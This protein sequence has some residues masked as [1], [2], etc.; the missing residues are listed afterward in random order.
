MGEG[1]V[2]CVGPNR[3]V[4]VGTLKVRAVGVAFEEVYEA[5]AVVGHLDMFIKIKV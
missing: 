4:V 3:D 2:N 5:A 1:F